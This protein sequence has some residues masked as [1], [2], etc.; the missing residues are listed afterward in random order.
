MNLI[1]LQATKLIHRKLLHF[2][3]TNSERSEGESSRSNAIYDCIK[4][5]K[6]LRNKPAKETRNL[7]SENSKMLIK[8][9]KEDTNRWRGYLTYPRS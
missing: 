8:E 9:I 7:Y 4:K 6:I 3:Y 1:T 2:L 5:N